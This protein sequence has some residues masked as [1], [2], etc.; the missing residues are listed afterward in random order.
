[1]NIASLEGHINDLKCLL[2][3]LDHNFDVIGITEN[4]IRDTE[5]ISNLNIDG[6]DFE[7]TPTKGFLWRDFFIY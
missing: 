3:I 4:K 1:M 5:S 2:S 6:Y 7:F